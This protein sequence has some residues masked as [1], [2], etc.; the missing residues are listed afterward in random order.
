ML[1]NPPQTPS[2]LTTLSVACESKALL[3]PP[4]VVVVV[5]VPCFS[6]SSHSSSPCHSVGS[7]CQMR[8]LDSGIG[9]FPLP[10]SVT[11]ASGRHIPKS[12]SSPGAV[13]AGSSESPSSHPDP[14]Q[15]DVKVPSLPKTRPHAPTSMGHSLSDPTVT[16]SGN[17]Q[18]AQSRLPKLATSGESRTSLYSLPG[19]LCVYRVLKIYVFHINVRLLM[20][21]WR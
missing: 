21:N 11:R 17:T 16:C 13:T 15:P 4:V 5:V 8:T 20:T 7:G 10:D 3:P 2:S 14:S 18:D 6:Q 1:L 19:E 12:E 9:T